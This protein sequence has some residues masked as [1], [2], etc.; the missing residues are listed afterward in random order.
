MNKVKWMS[1]KYG[2]MVH[3]L[4]QIGG[5][6]GEKKLSPEE[7]ANTF[8]VKAFADSIEKTGASWLIFPFGQN[9]GYYWSEN[10]Y[11]EERIPGR[12]SKRD[13]VLE[14]ANEITSRGIRF[15]AYIPTEMDF[16]SEE[17][18]NAFLWDK[19]PEKKEFMEI[20]YNVIEYYA[21]K[22]GDKLSGWWFD[23]CY[24]ASEKDFAR[25]KDWTNER[26]DR[27]RW[28]AAAKA[29]NPN[30][31]VA[32]GTG[33]N[34]MQCVFEEEEYLPG[35]VN[36]IVYYPWDYD[37]TDKQWHVLTY[38]DC[39]WMLEAGKI[40]PDPR[41]SDKELYDYVKKCIDKKGAVTLNMG[42]FEDGTIPEKTLKQ[43]C[44]LRDLKS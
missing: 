36:D 31:A 35:E 5:V 43:V 44:I 1:G 2:V 20:W 10:P 22:L 16:Q 14:I 3:Y 38:L 13:L 9:S 41:F 18:R 29:G 42:I 7:M 24:V 37:S 34:L 19:S 25:T 32:M 12:C 26:F 27:E 21:K 39:P 28:F 11:I 33:A 4:P 15:M 8:D 23:G 6:G 17:M 40:M 30:A